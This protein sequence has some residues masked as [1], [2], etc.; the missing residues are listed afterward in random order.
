MQHIPSPVAL[1]FLAGSQRQS[2]FWLLFCFILFLPQ[3]SF[4]CSGASY[5]WN[6]V[7]CFTFTYH[8]VFECSQV[9]FFFIAVLLYAI[10]RVYQCVSSIDRHLEALFQFLAIKNKASMNVLLHD[11]LWTWFPPCCLGKISKRGII[12]SQRCMLSLKINCQ[13]FFLQRSI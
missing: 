1:S 2:L 8:N 3:V 5:K 4:V 13:T 6:H 11:F 9:F 10:V 7:V 12:G